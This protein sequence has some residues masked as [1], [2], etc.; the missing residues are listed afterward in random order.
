MTRRKYIKQNHGQVSVAV[1]CSL[2][3]LWACPFFL[4]TP[5]PTTLRGSWAAGQAVREPSPSPRTPQRGCPGRGDREQGSKDPGSLA[6]H[7]ISQSRSALISLIWCWRGPGE[8]K[9]P[10]KAVQTLSKTE[11]ATRTHSA[12]R[13]VSFH[14]GWGP[15]TMTE[16][17]AQITQPAQTKG[18]LRHVYAM[19]A[20]I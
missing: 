17:S 20:L 13:R 15:L 18:A 1:R 7:H 19:Q 5:L 8:K 4:S 12:A 3:R 16:G 6:A 14:V 9:G 10:Q 2:Q 11:G